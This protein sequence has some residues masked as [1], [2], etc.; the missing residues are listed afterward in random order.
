MPRHLYTI[1]SNLPYAG[2]AELADAR[3]SKSRGSDTV[4]VRP[5]SPALEKALTFVSAFFLGKFIKCYISI[6]L[7]YH[8]EFSCINLLLF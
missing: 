3:D 1:Q 2:V 8:H 7:V 5:R 6:G 4:S